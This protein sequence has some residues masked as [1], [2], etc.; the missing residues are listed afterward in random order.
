[1][2]ANTFQLDQPSSEKKPSRHDP[3]FVAACERDAVDTDR[4]TRG[5]SC[6][7]TESVN[8]DAHLSL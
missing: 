1:M 4:T 7:L 3:A 5:L 2:T 6:R 8:Q